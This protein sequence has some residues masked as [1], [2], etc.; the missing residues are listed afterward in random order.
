M[1]VKNAFESVRPRGPDLDIPVIPPRVKNSSAAPASGN[2]HQALMDR[3][4]RRT[5]NLAPRTLGAITIENREQGRASN[6][7]RRAIGRG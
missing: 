6:D 7:R 1:T 2:V 5:V 3:N 4:G